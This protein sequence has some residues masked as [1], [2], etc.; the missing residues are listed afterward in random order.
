LAVPVWKFFC[1]SENPPHIAK[2]S[3]V[4]AMKLKAA[5]SILVKA[6]WASWLEPGLAAGL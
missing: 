2:P 6:G 3:R 5:F 1:F 4:M